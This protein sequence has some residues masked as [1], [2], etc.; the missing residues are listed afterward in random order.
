MI[1][2]AE[3][4]QDDEE[5]GFHSLDQSNHDGR[6]PPIN[7]TLTRPVAANLTPDPSDHTGNNGYVPQP[8]QY[9]RSYSLGAADSG[10]NFAGKDEEPTGLG[11]RPGFSH[12]D[13]RTILFT[14]LSDKTT[15]KDITDLV[16][17]G[18]LLDVYLRNDR[19]AT[20]SFVEGAADFM[21]YAK[22]NDLYLHTK[23]VSLRS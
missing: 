16:R 14:N 8:F 4:E 19:C 5:P 11:A 1:T 6:Q 7:I 20:V 18:R 13:Q 3:S 12:S 23:R 22:R 9:D 15:H 2:G 17:G 21:A 10:V